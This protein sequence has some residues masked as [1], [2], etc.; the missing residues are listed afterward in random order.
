M[1]MTV[2]LG[3]V[4]GLVVRMV[5]M[6]VVSMTMLMRQLGMFMVVLVA[7]AQM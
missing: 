6:F 1:P 5:M 3:Q 7:F 4:G 2:R